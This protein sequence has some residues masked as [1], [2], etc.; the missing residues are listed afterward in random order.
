MTKK[1]IVLQIAGESG[2]KQVDIKLVVQRTLDIIVEA[3]AAAE[4]VELRNFG[5]FKVKS[6]RGRTGR[7][8]RTGVTVPVPPKRVAVFK[9]GLIMKQKVK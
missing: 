7:N 6:R 5:I 9:P 3:L 8:P 1:E 2:L 4:T